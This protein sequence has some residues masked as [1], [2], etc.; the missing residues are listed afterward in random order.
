LLR[1]Q[2]AAVP[3]HA[4][5]AGVGSDRTLTDLGFDSP[6]GGELP[7]RPLASS[8]PRQPGPLCYAYQT[9]AGGG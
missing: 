9:A 4:D 6:T 8:V 7:H 3:G 5:T 2:I 1:A